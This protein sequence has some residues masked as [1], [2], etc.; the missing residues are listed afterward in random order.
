VS[1][2]TTQTTFQNVTWLDAGE[3][4][5]DYI[6]EI[7]FR[8][9]SS[10]RLALCGSGVI[11]AINK[12]IKEYGNYDFSIKTKAYGL[13]V[14]EWYTPFGMINMMTHPLF[15]YDTTDR[16]SMI[17]FEPKDLKYRFIDDTTFY[18]DPDKQNTGRGRIDGTDEEWLTECGL[19]FHHPIKC[20]YL[21]GFGS[22]NG[23]P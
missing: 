10:D 23:N 5:L 7:V 13:N 14:R 17:I 1:N 2:F 3:E 12:L 19:E 9:G 18:P 21:T 6:L 8:Y 16:N 11:L 15:S 4:W 20:A 22:D